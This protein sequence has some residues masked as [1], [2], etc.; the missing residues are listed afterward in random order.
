MAAHRGGLTRDAIAA[1]LRRWQ[2]GS[3]DA[4]GM[5]AW[6]EA[7]GGVQAGAGLDVAAREAIEA[8]DLLE[9]HLLTPEDVP[10]LLALLDG[11]DEA[12]VARFA[13]Y[14]DAI[15]LDGRSRALK[16]NRFYRPF[17]R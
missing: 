1:A 5:K 9:V 17:C 10:A 7:A 3:V 11:G 16:R 2:A 8:I 4:A 12:A 15:D 13:A 14:R 6:L